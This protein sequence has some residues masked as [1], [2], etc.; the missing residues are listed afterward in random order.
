MQSATKNYWIQGVFLT[1]FLLLDI[2]ETNE[3]KKNKKYAEKICFFKN[4]TCQMPSYMIYLF[5]HNERSIIKCQ[6]I[7]IQKRIELFLIL[8]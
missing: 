5:H 7:R 2:L 4:L 3:R 6:F 8:Q 1:F